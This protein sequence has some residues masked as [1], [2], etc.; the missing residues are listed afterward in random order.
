MNACL[1]LSVGSTTGSKDITLNTLE[2]NT[3]YQLARLSK[4]RPDRLDARVNQIVQC[5]DALARE[6]VETRLNKEGLLSCTVSP[7]H[8]ALHA[9]QID[10]DG[11]VN[12]WGLLWK[13]LSGSCIW[14]ESPGGSGITNASSPGSIWSRGADLSDLGTAEWCLSHR[15]GMCSNRP[16]RPKRCRLW[17]NRGGSDSRRSALRRHGCEPVVDRSQWMNHGSRLLESD[18][19]QRLLNKGLRLEPTEAIGWFNS[20]YLHQQRRIKAAIGPTAMLSL[21]A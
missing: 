8:A 13:L 14:G 20:D 3:R 1:L 19:W 6:Q 12:S 18:E 10:I 16:S 2:L 7:W 9:W 15:S 11:N 17:I 21:T 5:R 4:T